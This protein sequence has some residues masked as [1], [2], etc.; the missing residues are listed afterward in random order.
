MISMKV[1]LY[2][3]QTVNGQ[4]ARRNYKED[5]FTDES[6]DEFAKF[7]QQIGCF[8]VGRTTYEIYKK[9]R[10]S[11]YSF[12]KINA[13]IVV[14]SKRR[15]LKVNRGCILANSPKD[16][17]DKLSRF[18]FNKVL[19]AGGG[20]VNSS[21]MRS[22]LFDEIII[23]IEPYLLGNGI[24]VFSEANFESKLK[25]RRVKMLKFGVVQLRYAVVQSR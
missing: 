5:F 16:A 4:I 24:K 2:M 13:K 25:L 7:A 11:K 15:N 19:V 12:D 9:V 18:G 6:W 3:A 10:N 1:V 17:I 21:F 22:S 23:N 20:L 8:V 14:V